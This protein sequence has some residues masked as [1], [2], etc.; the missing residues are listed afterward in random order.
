[1]FMTIKAYSL[2]EAPRMAE[3]SAAL[4]IHATTA[5]SNITRKQCSDPRKKA[6]ARAPGVISFAFIHFIAV[7]PTRLVRCVRLPVRL[8]PLISPESNAQIPEKSTR[9]GSW[10]HKFCIYWAFPGG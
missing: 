1:M 2:E 10:G 4:H 8:P 5:S 9:P 6:H 7:T 3:L